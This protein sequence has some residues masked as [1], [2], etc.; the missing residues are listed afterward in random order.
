MLLALAAGWFVPTGWLVVAPGETL[1]LLAQVDVPPSSGTGATPSP[2]P[3]GSL[4]DVLLLTVEARPA[5]VYLAAATAL[6]LLGPRMLL[7]RSQVIPPGLD[8]DEYIRLSREQMAESIGLGSVLGLRAAGLAAWAHGGG[9]RV[10]SVYGG[11]SG[12]TPV[13]APGDLITGVDGEPV[14]LQGD[15]GILLR[16][17]YPGEAVTLAVQR[18]GVA[19]DLRAVLGAAPAGA[20]EL[21]LGATLVTESPQF[22]L[23]IP[24]TVDTE[25]IVGPSGGLAIALAVHQAVSSEDLLHGRLIAASGYVRA[26]GSVGPVGGA[27]LKALAAERAGVAVLFVAEANADEAKLASP[28]LA[29][30]G[31][32]H[33]D[34]VVAFLRS[35]SLTLE[36]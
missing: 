11:G 16:G 21:M 22:E 20:E 30:V 14:Q 35:A 15:L 26:D 31:V 4:G 24:I 19:L 13:L 28:G 34:E 9:A 27:G 10:V 32:T 25:G 7:R 17:R 36:K 3:H 5:N 6:G 23:P 8:G 29:V 2:P 12:R 18:G 1:R 33:F